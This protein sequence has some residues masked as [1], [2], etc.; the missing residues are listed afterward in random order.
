MLCHKMLKF[1]KHSYW[2]A[3][4][5][6]MPVQERKENDSFFHITSVPLFYSNVSDFKQRKIHQKGLHL[7]LLSFAWNRICELLHKHK[8]IPTNLSLL[9]LASFDDETIGLC[10]CSSDSTEERM[11][12][13]LVVS[14]N[15]QTCALAHCHAVADVAITNILW[16]I[17][18]NRKK[19]DFCYAA[20][21]S[22]EFNITT[23]LAFSCVMVLF[24]RSQCFHFN[25]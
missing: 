6:V 18:G 20:G 22:V 10:K 17:S 3:Q 2:H 9:T 23:K 8:I 25:L 12:L 11:W 5:A 14:T 7:N 21:E 19:Y 4:R 13:N 16:L 15:H 1:N 24:C